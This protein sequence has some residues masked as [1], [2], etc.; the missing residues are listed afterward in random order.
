[1]IHDDSAFEMSE[2]SAFEI[3]YMGHEGLTYFV[4][5]LLDSQALCDPF[6]IIA[7]IEEHLGVPIATYLK[8]TPM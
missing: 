5:N 1:V 6:D 3:L 4:E 7:A 8:E 2:F